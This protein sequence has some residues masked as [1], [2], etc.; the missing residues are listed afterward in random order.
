MYMDI[1]LFVRMYVHLCEDFEEDVYYKI[2]KIS[3]KLQYK[4]IIFK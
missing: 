4:P 2:R 1:Q 3:K